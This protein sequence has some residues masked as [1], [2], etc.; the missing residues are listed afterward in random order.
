MFDLVL[1]CPGPKAKGYNVISQTSST[2]STFTASYLRRHYSNVSYACNKSI[3]I[4]SV[5]L[6]HKINRPFSGTNGVCKS[7]PFSS[8]CGGRGVCILKHQKSLRSKFQIYA[9]LDVASAVDVINDL[10]LDTLTF[11]AVTVL[12]VPAFKSIKASPILGFFFAGV[13]LNQ[14]GLIRNITD[15]KVLSEWGILFLLF[16]MGL[17]LSLARLK[18]LAKFAFGMG[19]TQ[20]VLS[21]LAFTSFELPP[22]DAIGT[23]ILEFLFHSRPDLVNIRSV[24]EAV[25]IGAALS[26]SSSAFVLQILAEKG[27]L[28]T[29]FGSA[30]LGILLLQDIAVVP[31]LVILPVLETQNLIEESIL[32][33]LAKESLKALG[34]LGLLSLGG[35]YIWRRV[36]EVVAETRSSE[37]FVALCL[38]TVAGT[39]LLTQ[40]LGF[41]DTLGAFLAG[42]LLAETNF[43]TQIE[44]DIRP[45]RGL[46]LGLFFVT[47]GTSIDMQLLFREWPNVLSLLAGLI[48]IKTLIIT[49]IGPRVGLSLQESVRIGFL[50]S[51]GGEFG[52]V[53][54]SLANRLGV[55]PLELN[56]L[57]IIVVVLSMALTPLLNEIGRKASEFI[58]E[59]FDKEDRTAEMAN[60]DVSEP[61]VI[62]GFGQMGQ[63]LA[64]LLSTPLAS[65][66]GEEFRYVAF[67]LDPKVVKASRNLGFPVLYGDG[68]RPAVLQSA[69]ISSPKAVMVMY[70]GKDRTTEAVQRIRLAFPAVPIY[71]RAQD[72]MHLLDLK[73]VGATDA[74]LESAE[75]SLQLGSKLL[76]GFGVMS[77]DVTFLSQ[78]VRDSMELQAQE[79]VDKTDDQVS[80]VMKP[81]QVR[82]A[83]FV[84]NGK[85]ALSPR[86]N[87][88]TQDLMDRSYSS[89]AADES[90]DDGE[91][92]PSRAFE[93]ENQLFEEADMENA[94]PANLEGGGMESDTGE[95]SH[96]T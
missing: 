37:A 81:L 78:L 63:V 94:F 83:D 11:L 74:I 87:D 5:S 73:K 22:N 43:R 27:E 50:L 54:F 46:L 84:Q 44:A 3:H 51:Q 72:V 15:V 55:L 29:R 91:G 18:A 21:T 16:E 9:S 19:L 42:A 8:S 68:S 39:S 40:K 4:S 65:S 85:P 80:K 77:D 56:K 17:E 96:L 24:D 36:F 12:V 71:A 47:T 58:V 41:S 48:V 6:H 20:V 95:I 79:V 30:T 53:V 90:S 35:K 23:K 69:G 38:L 86:I 76:K 28:P 10:G 13:V 82:V 64:N 1:H 25:V 67:D 49:A 7:M 26:L 88:T 2:W 92:N 61:V 34:G 45:F 59:K 60:F 75:T 70:R 62:L 31:L 93:N 89:A 66:D 57:L 32:P 14:F 52:F 33:M